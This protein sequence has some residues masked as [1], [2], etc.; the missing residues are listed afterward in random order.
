[1]FELQATLNNDVAIQALLTNRTKNASD[2][3]FWRVKNTESGE[4]NEI[5]PS[6]DTKNAWTFPRFQSNLIFEAYTACGLLGSVKWI[7]YIH[8]TEL[9]RI[10]DWWHSMW[11]CGAGKCS[12]QHTDFRLCN[13]HFDPKCD[14]FLSM[15][16]PTDAQ[17]TIPLDDK[18]NAYKICQ[19]KD[20]N[21]TKLNCSNACWWWYSKCD[22]TVGSD[23][24]NERVLQE[25]NC[26]PNATY[27]LT[28][29][30]DSTDVS[31]TL[32]QNAPPA[33]A[34]VPAP[35]VEVR[36]KWQF[37]GF[38]C[39]WQYTNAL[40]TK[41][42]WLDTTKDGPNQKEIDRDIALKMQNVD[43]TQVTAKCGFFFKSLNADPSSAPIVRNRTKKPKQ[44]SFKTAITRAGT[45]RTLQTEDD[46]LK[47]RA[48]KWLG[49]LT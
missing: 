2:V 22:T 21:G 31:M 35:V 12:V 40:E 3:V 41:T 48:I 32:L 5:L 30:G 19:Y 7:I 14:T 36:I 42:F 4:W 43:V 20:N 8:R 38:Q 27:T 28:Q 45:L 1:M 37:H 47:T 18:A 26:G 33:P 13:F 39:K 11:T 24:C 29:P 25:G 16:N 15:L 10:D 44:C 6:G 46:T 9:I 17:N 23:E 49:T 34:P